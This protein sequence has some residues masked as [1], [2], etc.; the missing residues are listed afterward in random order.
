MTSLDSEIKIDE[1]LSY[2]V[3]EWLDKL[4]ADGEIG[5]ESINGFMCPLSVES[6]NGYKPSGPLKGSLVLTYMKKPYV[7][8][9]EYKHGPF[10][11]VLGKAGIQGGA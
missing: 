1:K 5:H 4:C 10:I 3:V 11:H 6:L 2:V 8:S 7:V 9:Y